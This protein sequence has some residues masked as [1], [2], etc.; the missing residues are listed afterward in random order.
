LVEEKSQSQQ[1]LGDATPAPVKP[2]PT[3][4]NATVGAAE[5]ATRQADRQLAKAAR[6]VG[7]K[8]T[9]VNSRTNLQAD[10]DGSTEGT[11]GTGLADG[12]SPSVA[13]QDGD[14]GTSGEE[15]LGNGEETL[16]NKDRADCADSVGADTGGEEGPGSK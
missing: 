3:P 9:D 11:R 13:G 1:A 15:T 10:A 12:G 4:V 8:D 6:A 7:N 16:G 5:A 14:H 2:A